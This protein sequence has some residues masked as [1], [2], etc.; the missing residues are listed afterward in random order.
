MQE[1]FLND[2]KDYWIGGHMDEIGDGAYRVH[3][4]G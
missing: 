2:Y 4:S 3:L 1:R